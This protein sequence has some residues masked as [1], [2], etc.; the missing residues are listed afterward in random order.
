M[1]P[2]P[3]PVRTG[4]PP[5]D[6]RQ[7]ERRGAYPRSHGGTV[8]RLFPCV[9]IMGLSPFARGNRLLQLVAGCARGPI[10]VRTGEPQH[11]SCLSV[12]ARAYPRSHGGTGLVCN[13]DYAS[14][15]LSPF[16]RGNRA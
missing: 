7:Y 16:A 6:H 9:T 12:L 13:N 14:K 15:G 10:P 11:A 5:P 3:I 4:E 8:N 2:G 1:R